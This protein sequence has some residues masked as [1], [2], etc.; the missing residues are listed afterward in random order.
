MDDSVSTLLKCYA[1]PYGIFE[2]RSLYKSVFLA[3]LISGH[4]GR[5]GGPSGL[6]IHQDL[7]YRLGAL[8][9]NEATQ[10]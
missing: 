3:G 2:L 8:F 7:K 6:H 10:L 4:G 5:K 9:L 1:L